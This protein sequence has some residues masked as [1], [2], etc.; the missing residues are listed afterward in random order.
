M[1]GHTDFHMVFD[2]FQMIIHP[3]WDWRVKV[4]LYIFSSCCLVYSTDFSTQRY[5][6]MALLSH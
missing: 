3:E 5:P 1:S 2:S 4:Y 6:F